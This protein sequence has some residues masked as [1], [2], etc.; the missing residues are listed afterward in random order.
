[1]AYSIIYDLARNEQD[2]KIKQDAVA[3]LSQANYYVTGL[4]NWTD[5][6]TAFKIGDFNNV[7][8][9]NIY[10]YLLKKYSPKAHVHIDAVQAFGK[11]KTLVSLDIN[12][13][14]ITSHKTGGPKGI[15]GLYLKKNHLVKPLLLGGGQQ[16]G[17]RSSTEN[18]P[19]IAGFVEAS[20]LSLLRRESRFNEISEYKEKLISQI[21]LMI[22][23][24]QF[25]FK[26]TSPY[27]F[28]FLLP[29][30]SSDIILRHLERKNIYI[31][32]TS[33]CSSRIKGQNPTLDALLIPLNL[34]KSILRISLGPSTNLEE[35]EHFIKEFSGTWQEISYLLK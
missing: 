12:S 21:K 5:K 10:R 9:D 34:Q 20:K 7:A 27:I 14:T 17:F 31:G 26:D 19:L 24:A 15:A 8:K 25:I 6:L 4:G 33:A 29:G 13:M 30:I 23:K 2:P 35:V 16:E 22:P 18:Y 32:S 28:S 3:T 11:I 1:M